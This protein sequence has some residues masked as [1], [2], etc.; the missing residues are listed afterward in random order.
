[1][2]LINDTI[3][4]ISTATGKAGIGIVRISGS[5]SLD[6]GMKMTGIHLN[7]R[8]AY[9]TEIKDLHGDCFDKGI[10]IYFKSPY[11]YTGEDIIE[12]H[13]HGG[14]EI[15]Q[16]ILNT[17]ISCGGRLAN[18]G[19]FTERAYLNNKIDLIQAEAVVDMINAT[20]KQAVKSSI[21]SLQGLFSKK[22]Y[23]IVTRINN[24]RI[25]IEAV[26]N[27]PDDNIDLFGDNYIL[28]SLK[29]FCRS[30]F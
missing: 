24:L 2:M 9:F 23:N 16:L 20:S 18:A 30:K 26:L 8:Y 11:S 4:A 12:F 14:L 25:Y 19:E 27:F 22:L 3:V 1:M 7:P 10:V 15:L 29:S 6:I 28:N 17:V 21:L 5:L 13:A